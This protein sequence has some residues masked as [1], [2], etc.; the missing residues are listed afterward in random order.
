MTANAPKGGRRCKT[1]TILQMEATECGAA[2]LAMILAYFGRW[3][4]LEELRVACDVSR[5]GS[6]AANV[7]RA[8]RRYGLA[9][10]GYRSEP[11]VIAQHR[12]P[13]IIFWNFNH[14]LVLEG[15]DWRR[16]KVWLNDPASGPRTVSVQEFDSA[17]TGVCLVFERTPEFQRGGQRPS[18]IAPLRQR[19]AGSQHALLYV[20]LV[21]LLL[22]LP[23][24]VI[25]VF[26]KVFID[27]IL[28]GGSE[29]WLMPLLIGMGATAV[30][31]GLLTWLQQFYLA[32]LEIKLA[33]SASAQFFWHVL[34]LPV[35]FFN[36]RY[37]GDISNRVAAN[38]Q[39][40]ALLSGQ[41]A[42]NIVGLITLVFYAAVMLAYD[43]GLTAVGVGLTLLNFAA[44]KAVARRRADS[45]RKL[46]TEQGKLSAASISGI[47]L[48]ET[49]KA[50]GAEGDFFAKWA[51]LQA[52]YLGAQ[53]E[54]A[55]TT[56]LISVVPVLL[57]ALSTVAILGL[58]G[59]LVIDGALTLGGLVAFQALLNN[60][61]APLQ[62]LVNF[63]G[64]LQTI[65]GQLA[66][67]DDVLHH[68]LEPRLEQTGQAFA[69]VAATQ[70]LP[71]KLRGHL[72]LRDL[73]FGYNRSDPPLINGLN[74]TVTPGQ[75]VA[76]VG[77]SGSG[78]ST[79]AK[80]VSGLYPPWS[81]Q[82][83]FDGLALEALPHAYF[84]QSVAT[85]DQE[86]CLFPGS[87]REN[88]SMW[89]ATMSE[90]TIT[91]ALRDACLLEA[92]ESRPGRYEAPV[93]ENG[94][95]FSGG[96]R[97]RL[98]IARALATNPSVLILDE[99]MSALDPIVERRIDENL[100]R[101]GCTCLIVAHRL[102][103]IR[104]CD[105]IIVLE[106]GQVAQRGRHEEMIA[107][108]G[109]YRRLIQSGES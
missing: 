19:L 61:S 47:Q 34:R 29:R 11:E 17:F 97:Q 44:L 39:V 77:G 21:T 105:E 53:Q 74:L 41:M 93:A 109:P 103:T 26:S 90:E 27:D 79:I 88:I 54:L 43:V 58:G 66:R 92:I 73:V 16:N 85:V 68:R 62:G 69:T 102:S 7:L 12:F 101:R 23:G 35:T 33:L 84:A 83:L 45:S 46:V 104:D 15:I 57:A 5:D 36:Q 75:R 56:T 30:L 3:V 31:N 59:F 8:A 14:F 81:G 6:N 64:E 86:I 52:K 94:G 25:P 100:R 28:I 55:A 60:F 72:E 51:G 76:L 108:E 82:V 50:S 24:L 107:V 96:Q 32:R 67:I 20:L 10:K 22:V 40:A 99:A 98:E 48:I 63:G 87:I 2:S 80:I 42:S 78:K 65:K 1:P 38:D 70:A 89:D 91:Q 18:L 9:A 106:R 37:P 71:E 13:M 4:P 49:L 95:N